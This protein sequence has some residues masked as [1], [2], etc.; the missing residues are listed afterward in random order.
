MINLHCRHKVSRICRTA[1][2]AAWQK[3]DALI[4]RAKL[5]IASF[6]QTQSVSLTFQAGTSEVE[7][8]TR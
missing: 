8:A 7:R 1:D 4:Y 6:H 5:T 3:K 2:C